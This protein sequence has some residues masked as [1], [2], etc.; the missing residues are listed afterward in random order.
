MSG[1]FSP[2]DGCRWADLDS[3]AKILG[4]MGG[5]L[6]ISAAPTL[7]AL[8]LQLVAAGAVVAGSRLSLRWVL[9]RCALVTPFAAMMAAFLAFERAPDYAPSLLVLGKAY[10]SVLLL[11][12]LVASTPVPELVAGLQRLRVPAVL[13]VTASFTYRYAQLLEQEWGRMDRARLSRSGRTPRQVAWGPR[14]A[15]LFVRSWD[16]GE[17]V[18]AAMTARGFTGRLPVGPAQ[19]LRAGDYAFAAG[20]LLLVLPLFFG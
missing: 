1:A 16:R 6:A 20:L 9:Q 2:V 7:A 18:A 13:V 4:T 19:A 3:R 10:G 5:A 8:G 11:G 17:R 15:A 12:I 14:L